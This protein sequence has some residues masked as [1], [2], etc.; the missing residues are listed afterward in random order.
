MR[1]RLLLRE[2]RIVGESRFADIVIWQLPRCAPGGGHQFKYRLAFV[3]DG[4][5]V[6]RFD[7]E[8]GKGDHKHV[9]AEQAHYAF[10]SLEQ[11]VTD[12]WNEVDNW[13]RP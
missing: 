3:V 5:C 12:F 13:S 7:N 6:L 1:A 8:A 11:L 2:R 10:I 4:V 9:G